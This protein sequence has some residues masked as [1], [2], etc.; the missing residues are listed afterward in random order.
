MLLTLYKMPSVNADRYCIFFLALCF[1][2]VSSDGGQY[3]EDLCETST[4]VA[5]LGSSVLLPCSFANTSHSSPSARD[6]VRWM[7]S[8][9]FHLVK[10]TSKGNI[11]FLDPRYGRV[12]AFPNQCSQGVFSIRIDELQQSDLG[13]YRCEQDDGCHQVEVVEQA[14]GLSAEERLLLYNAAGV[15]A[16]ILLLSA[17]SYWWVRRQRNESTPDYV[18]S[19]FNAGIS[20]PPEETRREPGNEQQR[21]AVNNQPVYDNDGYVPDIHQ[22]NIARN[23]YDPAGTP[24]DLERNQPTQSASEPDPNRNQCN[25]MESQRRKQGFHRELLSRLR[26]ASS[27]HYYVNQAEMNQQAMSSQGENHHRA[28]FWRKKAKLKSEYK[29]PIYN[30]STEQLNNL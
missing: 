6:S 17:C 22:D 5:P 11:T 13:C 28:S 21:G 30:N 2:Y 14:G 27:R 3:C 23:H 29:N 19:S 18:N 9:N 25:Q 12:K 4:L 24:Y 15:A 7:Q 26:Q 20:P 10:L 1:M 16:L 8:P